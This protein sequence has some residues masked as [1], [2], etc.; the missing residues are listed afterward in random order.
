MS[1]NPKKITCQLFFQKLVSERKLENETFPAISIC[2]PNTWKWPGIIKA[3]ANLPGE[4][5]HKTFHR[6]MVKFKDYWIWGGMRYFATANQ[7]LNS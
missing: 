4:P 7:Y 6:A 1:Q 3:A 2:Y 5:D